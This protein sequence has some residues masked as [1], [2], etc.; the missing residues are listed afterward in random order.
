MTL[1]TLYRPQLKSP[2]VTFD[3]FLRKAKRTTLGGAMQSVF[4]SVRHKLW[5]YHLYPAKFQMINLW[6]TLQQK[7]R[8]CW[9]FTQRH[10]QKKAV[11]IN[12]QKHHWQQNKMTFLWNVAIWFIL[13]VGEIKCKSNNA[14]HQREDKQPLHMK[15]IKGCTMIHTLREQAHYT[16]GRKRL[17][18]YVIR[19]VLTHHLIIAGAR[20]QP[21]MC[22][23]NCTWCSENTTTTHIA[24]IQSKPLYWGIY[25]N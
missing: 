18:L 2:H 9:H 8:S 19:L 17:R 11:S 16:L 20:A 5:I 23:C 12:N 10:N 6:V 4:V 7:H 24:H 15:L 21:T 3:C 1:F 14:W 22:G 25:W 13:Q